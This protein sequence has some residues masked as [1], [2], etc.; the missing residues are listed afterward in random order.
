MEKIVY[1]GIVLDT[2]VTVRFHRSNVRDVVNNR[3]LTKWEVEAYCNFQ[4]AMISYQN[5]APP[6]QPAVPVVAPGQLP[7]V[8]DLAIL[9]QL[10]IP[11]QLLQVTAG[12]AVVLSTPG[13]SPIRTVYPTDALNGPTCEFVSA[14]KQIAM[15]HWVV[16]VRF[17]AHT[18]CD[19]STN[20]VLSN[21]WTSTFDIDELFYPT[22]LVAGKAILRADLMRFTHATAD[23]F[24]PSFFFP[25]DV[26]YVREN[27]T[28]KLSEDGTTLLWS[29]MDVGRCYNVAGTSP[30][31]DID[32]FRI[33]RSSAGAGALSFRQMAT[34]AYTDFLGNATT[35][36]S[37]RDI[38]GAL[39]TGVISEWRFRRQNMPR[40]VLNTRVDIWGDRNCL[41]SAITTIGLGICLNQAIA[42]QVPFAITTS[43]VLCRQELSKRF[44][45]CE[46]TYKWADQYSAVPNFPII[47]LPPSNSTAAPNGRGGVILLN[48]NFLDYA[49]IYARPIPDPVGPF[50]NGITPKNEILFQR[51]GLNPA[52]QNN[53]QS[54]LI[55]TM[56]VQALL[57]PCASVPN[58]NPTGNAS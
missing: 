50:P 37:M 6:G 58:P 13:L 5:A 34:E 32:I 11:R 57:T 49:S 2:L 12:G 28:A 14:P 18:I 22:R 1:G 40:H 9:Q 8:T 24:R 3:I 55:E 26:N 36:T 53:C 33:T 44:V 54:T 43:E 23:V 29:F 46:I 17:L 47:E 52:P 20:V 19:D 56:V 48:S 4:P 51:D 30:I 45:S 39:H 16:H 7:G 27:C 10:L 25:L 15:R 21:V 38:G 31:R 41:M 42:S 35:Q